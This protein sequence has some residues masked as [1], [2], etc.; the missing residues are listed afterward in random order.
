MNKHAAV[1]ILRSFDPDRTGAITFEQLLQI[2]FS[3]AAPSAGS[4]IGAGGSISGGGAYDAAGFDDAPHVD[5]GPDPK[6]EDSLR[7]L[8][9]YRL[10]CESEGNYEEAGRATDQLATLRKQEEQRR[11][12]ALKARHAGEKQAMQ[13]AHNQQYADFNAAWDRYL[14]EY[15][16][17]AA[18]YVQ[19]MQERHGAKLREYQEALHQ[20]LL[21]K[22]VKYSR[23]LLDW[24]SREQLLA[25]YVASA[26]GFLAAT[27]KM[28]RFAAARVCCS[29][30]HT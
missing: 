20:E 21:R 3:R 30:R 10:K 15:D 17:M 29:S 25:R 1:A 22:P 4:P 16:A 7:I 6:V 5:E 24:R 9:E 23:E 27:E 12:R 8:E 14:A 26:P 11:I 2:A 28:A 19:Q 13:M 18:M